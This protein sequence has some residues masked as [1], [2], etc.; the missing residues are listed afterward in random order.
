MKCDQLQ[1]DVW[2]DPILGP[3]GVLIGRCCPIDETAEK[4]APSN[5]SASL[6]S[7][8]RVGCSILED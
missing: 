5:D 3:A 1:R 4:L 2:Q 6:C 8:L 7:F